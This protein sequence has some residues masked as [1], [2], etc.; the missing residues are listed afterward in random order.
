MNDT[1]K[2]ALQYLSAICTDYGA[3]MPPSVRGPVMR[4]CQ[5]ALAAIESALATAATAAA[6]DGT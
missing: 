4:E 2:L 1:Q 5:T 6:T 3:T